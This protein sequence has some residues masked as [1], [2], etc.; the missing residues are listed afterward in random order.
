MTERIPRIGVAV[1]IQRGDTVLVGQR[2]ST[3]HGDGTWQFPGGHLEYGETVEACAVREA[4]E[5]TGLAV[6]VTGRGPWVDSIFTAEDRHYVT[7]FVLT[8]ADSGEAEAREPDKCA[9]WQWC[10][11][12]ALPEPLFTPIVELRALGWRPPPN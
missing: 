12:D 11:W 10:A 1:I 4:R 7:L 8:H 9:A 3:T 6:R 5:E 2:R